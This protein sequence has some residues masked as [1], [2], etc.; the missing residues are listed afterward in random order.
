MAFQSHPLLFG[1]REPLQAPL[2]H[3]KTFSCCSLTD[4]LITYVTGK[5]HLLFLTL[6]SVSPIESKS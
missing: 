4:G 6:R 3:L 1:V 2:Q 5:D